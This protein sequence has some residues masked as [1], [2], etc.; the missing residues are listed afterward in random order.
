M[1]GVLLNKYWCIL[2]FHV[3]EWHHCITLIAKLVYTFQLY[4]GFNLILILS[5][6]G[7]EAEIQLPLKSFPD[8]SIS[9]LIPVDWCEEE[10]PATKN[11]LQNPHRQLP[12]GDSI[13]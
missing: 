8:S 10:H 9:S 2:Q 7:T 13:A 1:L 11:L 12:Y 3:G 6:N 4:I 5:S